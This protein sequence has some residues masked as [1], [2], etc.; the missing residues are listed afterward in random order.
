MKKIILP[1]VLGT[2]ALASCTKDYSCTCTQTDTQT[3]TTTYPG[4]PTQTSTSTS[5]TNIDA[6]VKDAKKSTAITEDN[7]YG[8]EQESTQNQGAYTTVN[9]KTVVD[10]EIK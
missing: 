4:T 9:T 10:C 8:Y 3:T 5:V 2:L 6:K 7:C 1:L